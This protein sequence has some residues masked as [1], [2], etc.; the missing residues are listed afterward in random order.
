MHATRFELQ[1]PR[2]QPLTNQRYLRLASALHH[3]KNSFASHIPLVPITKNGFW[4]GN[5]H[6]FRPW[7]NV[8]YKCGPHGSC[9][10]PKSHVSVHIFRSHATYSHWE[11]SNRI[12]WHFIP[13]SRY[14]TQWASGSGGSAM[15]TQFQNVGSSPSFSPGRAPASRL[16]PRRGPRWWLASRDSATKTHGCQKMILLNNIYNIYKQQHPQANTAFRGRF[17]LASATPSYIISHI[18]VV[19][20]KNTHIY[21]INIERL[22][23]FSVHVSI[24]QFLDVSL[25]FRWNPSLFCLISCG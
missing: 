21:N 7:H 18:S 25:P 2:N 5:S 13:C 1:L 20:P 24:V 16:P 10:D 4:F 8:H 3:L 11:S 22:L 15:E 19:Q 23:T 14:V 9:K 17:A 12:M 6:G